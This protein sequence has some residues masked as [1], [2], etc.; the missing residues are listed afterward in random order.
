VS[1]TTNWLNG[2]AQSVVISGTKSSCNPVTGSVPQGPILSPILFNISINDLQD[3]AEGTLSK[4][5]DDTKLGGEADMPECHAA[6]QRGLNRLAKQ[7]DRNLIK[8]NKREVLHL[9]RNNP[10]HQYMASGCMGALQKRTWG[11]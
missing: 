10:M 4:L 6:T 1:W 8:F 3:G 11:S 5:T 2:Q 7:A 9:L